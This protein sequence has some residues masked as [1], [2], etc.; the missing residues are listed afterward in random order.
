MAT[1][2]K[3]NLAGQLLEEM[4]IDGELLSSETC[5]QLIKDYLVALRANARQWSASTKTRAEVCHSGQKPHPQKG[6]GRARQGYLGSPQY[7]GGGRVFAPRPKFDQF[8]RINRK[9]RRAAI[10]HLLVEKI[11]EARLH[12][13]DIGGLSEPKTKVVAEF[14]RKRELEGKRVLFMTPSL[15]KEGG[16]RANFLKSMRNIPRAELRLMQNVNGYD[17][18]CCQDVIVVSE[19]FDELKSLLSREA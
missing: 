4:T 19:A 12:V 6:T 8:V 3:Y 16:D 2:K 15:F 1:I 7:K 14:L 13:L 11:R 9:E 5:S 18:T 10:R 17:V